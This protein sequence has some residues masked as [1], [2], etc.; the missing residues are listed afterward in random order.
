[1]W[2][3]FL[4]YGL[5]IVVGVGVSVFTF[6]KV[7]AK[8]QGVMSLAIY[9][10]ERVRNVRGLIYKMVRLFMVPRVRV[11]EKTKFN[12]GGGMCEVDDDCYMGSAQGSIN[13]PVGFGCISQWSRVNKNTARRVV[14]FR[15]CGCHKRTCKWHSPFLW[16]F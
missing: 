15:L 3:K 13:G 16:P 4:I 14:G 11:G 6:L 9:N 5:I 10:D 8:R 12:D 7:D 2:K 1:M